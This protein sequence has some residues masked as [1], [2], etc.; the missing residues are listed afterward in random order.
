MARF[1]KLTS[2]QNDTRAFSAMGEQNASRRRSDEALGW[3]LA[4]PGIL[5]LTLLFFLPLAAVLGISFTDW[6]FG[7]TTFNVVGV[8]NFTEMYTDL[9]F[10]NSLTNTIIYAAI[11]VPTTIILGLL[12][13]MLIETTRAFA[14]VYRAIHFL[15]YM[16][17]MAAMALAW[18][19][20]LNPTIG[21]INK[22]FSYFGLPV[23]NWL[24]DENTVLPVLAGIAIWQNIGFS[25]V[26]FLAGLKS[27]SAELY[28]A[29]EIDGATHWFDRT[30][31]VT[32]PMLGPVF[33]FVLVVICLKAF[34][35]FDTVQV[36]TQGGPGHA[37]EMLLFTIYR[38]S[39]QYFRTGY[40]AAASIV[41]LSIVVS[42]ALVQ[43]FA[44]DKKVHY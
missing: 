27:I 38:E 31:A 22:A 19:A 11:V 17:T 6:Q 8:N 32:L 44:A 15:P 28:D 20:L 25:M 34:E 21:I 33:L 42:L 37:S 14:V 7:A 24:R 10:R 4:T 3:A 23:A 30:T 35:A 43:I 1:M 12:L 9:D 13:A 41:F 2:S 16:A 26:L 36:L 29:A 40:G 18:D 5:L 39:F